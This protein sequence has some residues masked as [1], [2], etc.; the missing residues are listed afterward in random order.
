MTNFHSKRPV[1]SA[2]LY[3]ILINPTKDFIDKK[4]W[5]SQK[6]YSLTNFNPILIKQFYP[7]SKHDNFVYSSV[8]GRKQSMYIYMEWFDSCK[9]FI[10]IDLSI[11]Y[12]FMCNN[13]KSKIAKIMIN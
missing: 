6:N 11:C 1:F 8:D 13:I 3:C 4:N 5:H 10:H 12:N 7:W 2:F 9:V